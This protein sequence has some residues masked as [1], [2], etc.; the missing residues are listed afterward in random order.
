MARSIPALSRPVAAAAL[1][2][3]AAAGLAAVGCRPETVTGARDRLAAGE[4]RVVTYRLPL[5]REEYGALDFLESTSTVILDGG[6]IAVPVLPDTLRSLVGDAL[7]DGGRAEVEAVKRLD[8]SSLD[9]GELAHAVAAAELRTAPVELTLRH[10]SDAT[11]TLLRPTLVLARTGPD[12]EPVRDESGDLVVE[13]DASGDSLAV[14]VG[15]TVPVGPGERVRLEPD[16]APLVDRMAE[17]L[18]AGES[19]AVALVGSV[20]VSDAERPL[21]EPDDV[22]VLAHRALV[23][24]DMVLPDTGVVVRRQE[25]GDGLGFSAADADQI[26]SRVVGAGTRLV[27]GNEIPFRVRVD[28]AYVGGERPDADVF[29]AADRVAL[30]SLEVGGGGASDGASVDTVSVSVS[31]GELRPLLEEAFTAGV[32]I[33]LLPRRGGTGRGALRVDEFVDVDARVFV[34]VRS[35]GGGSGSPGGDGS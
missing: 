22:L 29:A 18:V 8:P 6:L 1:L 33:R 3:L 9:L 20:R 26:E 31:G 34:E 27:V 7:A 4:S 25:I 5:A 30:D 12:G 17:R 19:V 16:G 35:G 13:T 11:L 2:L 14:P 32:R 28:L 21:V 24:L 10:T 23:G 15:D